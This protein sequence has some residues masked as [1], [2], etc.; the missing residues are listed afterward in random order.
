MCRFLPHLIWP[1]IK[2]L[3]WQ[4]TR[5][6]RDYGNRPSTATAP[7]VSPLYPDVF[8][9]AVRPLPDLYLPL[10]IPINLLVFM[11]TE[12]TPIDRQR[13][14]LAHLLAKAVLNRFPHAKPTLGPVVEHGFYYDFDFSDGATPGEDDLS[15][16]TADM[17]QLLPKW[18]FVTSETVSAT[19]ARGLF[20]EN[21]Y[22]CEI[23]D[24]LETANE[25]ITLYTIG[26]GDA[27]FTDLCRG[28]HAESPAEE[29]NPDAFTLTAIS[30][31]Y[32]RGDENRPMLTRIYGVAF[33]TP[34]ELEQYQKHQEEAKARDH[35]K[36]GKELDLFTFSDLVGPGLPLFTPKG[37]L[38]RQLITD[39]ISR[40]QA[41][42]GY[43][44]VTIPHITKSELYKTSGH[45]EKFGDELFKVRGASETEFVMKPMNCPH[46]TQIFASH[47]RSYKDLPIRYAENTMVYRDE[48]HGELL[49]LSR[50]RA[51]TQDDGHVFCTPEQIETEVR[52]ITSVIETFYRSLGMY[53]AQTCWVSLSVRD[54]ET[55]EDYLGDPT[56]WNSAETVL[57][58]IAASL[59]LPYKRIPGEAAF[60]GPKLDF[61]FSDAL[62]RER[63]L[64]TAQLDFVMPERFDLRYTDA[65]GTKQTPVMIHRA[66]AGSLERFMAIMIEHFAGAFPLWLSPE[67]LRVIPIAEAHHDYAHR[68]AT[69]L[70]EAG[71]RVSVDDSKE[72]MGKRI[73]Q[74]KQDKLPYV[75]VIGDKEQDTQTLTIEGREETY[76]LTTPE[77]ITKLQ[78]ELAF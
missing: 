12:L 30:G 31:A 43:R 13:H 48:Q 61:M 3:R 62:G 7:W 11:S 41:Q 24:E 32:W 55:P 5:W 23:I 17:Q 66:I 77:L 10:L 47:P 38:M 71:L 40:I 56:T 54:P 76:H 59:D 6:N 52:T 39:R 78:K 1:S 22:K 67:Q 20:H 14:T 51:I 46:H 45:W 19:D 42:Y 70:Q 74:A 50:V 25:D 27:A 18:K 33:A 65:E 60:Y 2:C 63:Q 28:G 72:S 69:T 21:E 57:E 73:R 16:L 35:R 36:L 4:E 26:E 44:A 9:S 68:Q 64:A 58:E 34:A 8:C 75:I 29:I 49:G 37:T 53:D 15:L